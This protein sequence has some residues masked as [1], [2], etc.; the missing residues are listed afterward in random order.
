MLSNLLVKKFFSFS[1]EFLMTHELRVNLV[2]SCMVPGHD[3]IAVAVTR[4]A[5]REAS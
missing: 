4:A 5:G 3:G 2:P 1:L